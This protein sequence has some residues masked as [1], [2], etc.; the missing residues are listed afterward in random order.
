MEEATEAPVPIGYRCLFCEEIIVADESGVI[1]P[2]LG[3]G[4]GEPQRRPGHIECWLRSVLGSVAHQEQ[5]CT[6]FGGSIDDSDDRSYRVQARELM[7][8]LI[9]HGK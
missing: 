6:C 9:E 2:Y 1:T 5:R 3:I 8:W 7:S 4:M